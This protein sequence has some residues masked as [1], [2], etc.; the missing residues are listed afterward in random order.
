MIDPDFFPSLTAPATT[1][2]VAP[3]PTVLP[4]SEVFQGLHDTGKRT[5]W[6]VSASIILFPFKFFAD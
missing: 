2:S 4:G 6:Y 5:L 3:I 1:S